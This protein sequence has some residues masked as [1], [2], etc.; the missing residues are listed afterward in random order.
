MFIHTRSTSTR[1]IPQYFGPDYSFCHPLKLKFIL[2]ASEG[3]LSKVF[4]TGF[5]FSLR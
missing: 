2:H 3:E 4:R 1:G 5:G